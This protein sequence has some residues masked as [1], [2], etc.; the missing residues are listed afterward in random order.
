MTLDPRILRNA[1]GHFATGVTVI[2]Y[3]TE[4]GTRHG[5]TVN[6]FT[7][8]SLEPP[9]I[10]VSLRRESRATDHL[11]KNPF[12]VNILAAT[13]HSVAMS[14]AGRKQPGLEVGWKQSANGLAPRLT[15]T[16]A[17][18]ECTPWSEYDGGDH[19]LVLGEVQALDLT[20]E[21]P[22]LFFGGRFRD[23]GGFPDAIVP[24]SFPET[25]WLGE[26]DRLFLPME[27]VERCRGSRSVAAD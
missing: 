19:V 18:F 13:Q 5:M 20:G 25:G 6:A 23:V 22:L 15:G 8:V 14:F 17:W 9:L 24:L 7:A 12:V 1:L 27:Y 21:D 10:L 26:T 4:D 3:Q 16:S 11:S 2:T